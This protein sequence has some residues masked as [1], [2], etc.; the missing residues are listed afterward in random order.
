MENQTQQS[1]LP[2]SGFREQLRQYGVASILGGIVFAILS[3]YLFSR[4]GYYDLFIMNKVFAGTAGILLSIVLL[5]GPLARLFSAFDKYILYRKEIGFIAFFF[6]IAHGIISYFFLSDH[7]LREYFFTFGLWPFISALIGTVLLIVIFLISNNTMMQC[8]GTGRW[9]KLQYWGIR[10]S[11]LAIALHVGIM[12]FP[13]WISWYQ[14]GGGKEL[15]HPEWPGG[16]ILVGWFMVF[17]IIFRIA[18][19]I[20]PVVGRIAWYSLS[21][22]LLLV[23]ILTFWWGQQ[24]A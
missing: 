15:L 20:H 18:E 6:A 16:G 3:F 4:R 21:C 5:F 8:I 22:G 7:F 11:F 12:K 2:S 19:Y 14:H 1:V 13:E 9:W 17:V 23:Y 10:I 24:F